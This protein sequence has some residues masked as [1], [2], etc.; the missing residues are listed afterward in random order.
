MV[1]KNQEIASKILK[2]VGGKD[3]VAQAIH[4][5]TRL[6]L[7]LKDESLLDVEEA[8]K[9]PGVLNVQKVGA[10]QQFIIGQNVA[11]VYK[12]FCEKTGMEMG[13]PIEES[14]VKPKGIKGIINAILDGISGCINPILPAITVAGLLKLIAALIG[15]AMLNL[16][17]ETSDIYQLFTFAGNTA[18]YFFPVLIGYSGAKKFGCNP[19]IGIVMG[20]IMI[21]PT[22]IDIVNAGKGFTVYGIPMTLVN[23]SN[24]VISMIM[25]TWVMSYV[26]KY[27][28]KFIPDLLKSMLVPLL[29]VLIMLPVA[30][31]A[32]GPLGTF[33]GIWVAAG[34]EWLCTI[35]GPFAGA[36]TGALWPFL[37][38]TGMH[39]AVI[40][41]GI[42]MLALKG[43][44]NTV[45]LGAYISS[46][47]YIGLSLGAFLK[48]KD[49]NEKSMAFSSFCTQAFGGIGEPILFG[50]MLRYKKAMLAT[51]LSGFVGGLIASTFGA[52]VYFF[53]SSNFLS[54]LSFAGVDGNSVIV[55]FI[56]SIVAAIV[57]CGFLLI[58]GIEND[59]KKLSFKRK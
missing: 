20:A 58:F 37:V 33:V 44:D 27:L 13:S 45:L 35:A 57:S 23:Y 54:F 55:G 7:N 3:N 24:N 5:M 40:P 1:N 9:I 15:P 19:V 42:S 56:A 49:K 30:L 8:K 39:Q 12:S 28:K 25:I 26:E 10:Q 48:F 31:C 18:F 36:V 34:M 59:E 21:H 11:E 41:Y 14:F 4:C 53:G 50:I 32:L 17:A 29:T 51:L 22:L 43:F 46:Y 52:K 47:T 6:R 38:T 16:V 2:A